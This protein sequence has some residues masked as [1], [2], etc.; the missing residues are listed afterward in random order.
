MLAIAT[1]LSHYQYYNDTVLIE[2]ST[3]TPQQ[4]LHDAEVKL[5]RN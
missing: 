4:K 2:L 5:S 1:V 3:N